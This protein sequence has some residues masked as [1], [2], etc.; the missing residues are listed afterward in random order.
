[1]RSGAFYVL[2]MWHRDGTPLSL[3]EIESQ[4]KWIKEDADR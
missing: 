3:L 2:H 1:M 4:L